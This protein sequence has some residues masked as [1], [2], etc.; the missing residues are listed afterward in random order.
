MRRLFLKIENVKS[1]P[2]TLVLVFLVLANIHIIFQMKKNVSD[3][4]RIF[5]F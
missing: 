2:Q 3:E 5:M 1:K 4:I